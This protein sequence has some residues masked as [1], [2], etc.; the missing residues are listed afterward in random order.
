[1]RTHFRKKLLLATLVSMMFSTCV[2]ADDFIEFDDIVLKGLGFDNVDLTA[3]AGSNDQFS[4]EYL[5]EIN[6][7]GERVAR[8]YS[9]SF[10]QNSESRLC[11]TDELLDKLAIKKTYFANLKAEIH[12]ID[13]GK[14]YPVESLDGAVAVDFDSSAQRINIV[15][16]QKFL[17]SLDPHWVKPNDRDHGVNGI[18]LDYSLMWEFARSDYGLKKQSTSAVRSLG[19]AGFNLD[20]YRFRANYQYSSQNGS[21]DKL[22][23]TQIYGFTDIAS[24]NSK[25][26]AGEIYTRSAL[27]DGTRIK[28]LSLYS[29]ENMMPSYLKGYAPQITGIANSNAVV[30]IKQYDNVLKT[31]QVPAGPF[32]ISDLPS[33]VSGTVNVEIEEENGDVRHYQMDVAHVPFLTRKGGFRYYANIGTLDPLSNNFTV[34]TSLVSADAS[35]G[36]TNNISIFGGVQFT[37]NH[38]YKAYNIGVGINLEQF[39]A[40]SFDVTRSQS[41]V[42]KNNNGKEYSGHSYRFNYAKRFDSD[43]TL[44]IAGYRFSSR[45]FTS[46]NNYLSFVQHGGSSMYLEKN[47]ISLS[48]SQYVSKWDVS[49]TGSLSKGTYWNQRGNSNYNL[50]MSKTIRQGYLKNVSFNAT[51]SQDNGSY[52]AGKDRRIGIFVNIPLN[53]ETG[54]SIQYSGQYGSAEKHVNHQATYSGAGLGGRYSVG[55]RMDHK[56]DLSGSIDYGLNATYNLETGYGQFMA[57]ADHSDTR[58][59]VRANFDSAISITQH[60]VATHRTVY[61]D[62]SRLILNAGAAGVEMPGGDVK[63]N[64]F[65][66]MGIENTSSYRYNTY[67]I[68]N[69]SLPDNVEIQDGVVQV[70]MSDG[71]IA[72]RS[73]RGISGEKA[74]AKITLADGS[75]PPFGAAVYRKNGDE[76]EVAI[77][78]GEG[79]TYLT[80]L[81]KNSEYVIRWNGSECQLRIGNLNPTDFNDLICD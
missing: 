58:T 5:V 38:H 24:L 76:Q 44:N 81:N 14:C 71:A 52:L 66:L 22:K 3:F 72:Y 67:A 50:T 69:D 13:I 73:L 60:G 70:A 45:E 39:G 2:Q 8:D 10:Y 56:R 74:I 9:V 15:M 26:Y 55:S 43:T 20:R 62:G 64:V 59:G 79:L 46:L 40:L 4:G 51:L 7:N 36:L 6:L 31:V 77:V 47:R 16:P 17:G 11:F 27:F 41:S 53:E 68:D 61:N 75:Y 30:V 32:L 37:T 49:F 18:V 28:G 57:F 21:G 29:D 65:G 19:S 80:G 78:A 42:I 48:I 33:Y 34:D 1:M 23:W 25:L 35:Y 12:E 54:S 63:S